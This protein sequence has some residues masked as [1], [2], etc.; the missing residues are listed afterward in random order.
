MSWCIPLRICCRAENGKGG[1]ITASAQ[2][3]L[4]L[5]Q[6]LLAR[7]IYPQRVLVHHFIPGLS[8]LFSQKALHNGDLQINAVHEQA[9]GIAHRPVGAEDEPILAKGPPQKLEGG[10]IPG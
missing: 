3:G 7:T 9:T 2:I 8:V 6:W 4:R 5:P 1:F 10:S